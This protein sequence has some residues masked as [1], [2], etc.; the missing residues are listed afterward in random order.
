ML[1][2]GA[3]ETKDEPGRCIIVRGLW[4]KEDLAQDTV[5]IEVMVPK[6]PSGALL[7]TH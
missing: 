5:A 2:E 3:C 7:L 6:E 1:S 4:L